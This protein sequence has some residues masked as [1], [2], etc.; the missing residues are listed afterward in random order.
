MKIKTALN[1]IQ[2]EADFLGLSHFDTMKFIAKNPLAQP[3]KTMEAFTTIKEIVS[4]TF[5]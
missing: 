1:I 2:K 4:N 5:E 3:K